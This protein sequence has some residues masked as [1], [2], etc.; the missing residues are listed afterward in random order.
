MCACVLLS[1]TVP[2]RQ[3]ITKGDSSELVKDDSREMENRDLN[4]PLVIVV[5]Q[6]GSMLLVAP[7]SKL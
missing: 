5:L 3:S 1:Q 4:A 2:S 7:T 6:F